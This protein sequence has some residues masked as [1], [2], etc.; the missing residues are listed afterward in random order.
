VRPD[1]LTG[2]YYERST[3]CHHFVFACS[4]LTALEP[5]PSS[6]EITD[7]RWCTRDSLPRPISDFTVRRITDALDGRPAE[8]QEIG[9]RVWLR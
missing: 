1:R 5:R 3:E 9:A 8:L 7:I 6:A 2:V 4:A